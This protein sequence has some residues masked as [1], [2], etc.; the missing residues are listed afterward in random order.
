M[1][2]RSK[3]HP[4][5][6]ILF[7]MGAAIILGLIGTVVFNTF[8]MGP[9]TTNTKAAFNDPTK[10]C[11]VLC[12]LF[13]QD[14]PVTCK[15]DCLKVGNGEMTADAF[16][17]QITVATKKNMCLNAFNANP[18]KNYCKKLYPS[19]GS[20]SGSAA[21]GAACM[22]VLTQSQN[23]KTCVE[24]CKNKNLPTQKCAADCQKIVDGYNAQQQPAAN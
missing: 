19:G 3:E 24:I 5:H 2:N 14:A 20:G 16:C 22:S 12:K 13:G 11:E 15:D 21:Y 7:L 1:A 4:S 8:N 6:L 10:K 9:I 17:G 23:G 18:I